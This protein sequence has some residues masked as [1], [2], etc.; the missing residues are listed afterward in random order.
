MNSTVR[1]TQVNT[2]NQVQEMAETIE[3]L[4]ASIAPGLRNNEA[5]KR[6]YAKIRNLKK[7]LH[8]KIKGDLDNENTK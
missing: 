3:R 7:Q 6:K 5:L 1:D 2:I 4:W 8:V